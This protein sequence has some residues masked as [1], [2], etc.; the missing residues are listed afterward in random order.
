MMP[1]LNGIEL[2]NIIKNT[3]D[4]KHIPFIFLTADISAKEKITDSE[5]IIKPISPS[6]IKNKI[7]NFFLNN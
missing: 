1:K 6:I 4:L 2:K 7:K 5:V 3:P